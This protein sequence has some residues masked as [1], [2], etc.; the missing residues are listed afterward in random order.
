MRNVEIQQNV[1]IE[2]TKQLE[3]AK[4]D[5]I[6][7]APIVNIKEIAQNPVEKAGPRRK[8]MFIMILFFSLLV[9]G[10][11]Y[12]SDNIIINTYKYIKTKK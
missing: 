1:Y 12:L 11:Y 4:I 8:I 10:T 3:L 9:S 6:K 2:L 7:D 5:E